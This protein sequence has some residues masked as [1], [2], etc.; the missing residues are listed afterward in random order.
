[1]DT[2]TLVSARGRIAA[3]RDRREGREDQQLEKRAQE[4]QS[5]RQGEAEAAGSQVL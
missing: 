3:P 1:M 4:G 5:G 2:A